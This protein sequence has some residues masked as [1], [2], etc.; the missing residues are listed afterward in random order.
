MKDSFLLVWHIVWF[1]FAGWSLRG[2]WDKWR[3]P[4]KPGSQNAKG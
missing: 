1:G 2:A 4:H 3:T